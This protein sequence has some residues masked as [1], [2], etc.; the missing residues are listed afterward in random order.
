M[1]FSGVA[2]HEDVS[3]IIL[4]CYKASTFLW[5]LLPC[6]TLSFYMHKP[7]AIKTL[8]VTFVFIASSTTTSASSSLVS[9]GSPTTSII[10]PGVPY[11]S[12]FAITCASGLTLHIKSL[13]ANLHR[14]TIHSYLVSLQSA[15]KVIKCEF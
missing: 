4:F 14:G 10:N 7:L 9:E 8:D 3:I 13:L 5:L 6:P 12:S 15:T 1:S 2:W 11:A